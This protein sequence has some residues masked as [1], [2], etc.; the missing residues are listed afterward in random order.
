MKHSSRFAT[1]ATAAFLGFTAVTGEAA[2]EYPEE[3][4]RW[5][6][7]VTPGGATDVMAR[8]L[9]AGLEAELGQ[10]LVIENVSGGRGARQMAELARAEPDGYTIGSVTATHI[11]V[12]NENLKQ[13]SVDEIDWIA[14]L[15]LEPYILAV[16]ADAPYNTMQ[17][18]VDYVKAHPGELNAAGFVRGSGSHIAWEIFAA[19]AGITADDVRWIP[20][21]SVGDAVVSLLGG[22]TGATFAYIDLV[23][24]HVEAGTL[25]VLGIMSDKRAEQMPNVPT[26]GESGFDVDTSW[27]QFRG[28]IGPKGIPEDRK[29]KLASAVEKALNTPELK[30]YLDE[31][32]LTYGFQGPVDFT[33][34]AKKQDAITKE[35]FKKL[36]VGS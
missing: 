13:Y 30:A 6:L 19:S 17:E 26:F 29:Q 15:V 36:G 10:T 9:A 34:F 32:G 11:G 14:R 23:Q 25:K 31:A 16:P 4:I 12:F 2:A 28:I 8:K 20:F 21:D 35:W 27:Q 5:V 24:D 3:P 7:H 22:H 1:F 33:T 18:F